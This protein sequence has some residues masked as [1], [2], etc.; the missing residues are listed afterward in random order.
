MA[1]EVIDSR[2][3]LRGYA[4]RSADVWAC[5]VLLVAMLLGS[6]PYDHVR[7]SDPNTHEAQMEVW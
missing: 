2:N 3:G 1:P 7:N 4:G 5:G 6:F